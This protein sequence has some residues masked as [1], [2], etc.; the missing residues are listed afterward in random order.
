LC[1]QCLK[2]ARAQQ[3]WADS[4]LS[5]CCRDLSRETDHKIRKLIS[6][7][8]TE[9]RQ[10]NYIDITDKARA[11]FVQH[12]LGLKWPE[13]HLYQ[14]IFDAEM[15]ESGTA[16]M[17]VEIVQQFDRDCAVSIGKQPQLVIRVVG[18]RQNAPP[19]RS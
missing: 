13:T 16:T 17:L 5:R 2:N 9:D 18:V 4:P 19:T 6:S 1:R 8:A 12:Y 3:Q 7:G 11:A 14:A 10:S 15:G